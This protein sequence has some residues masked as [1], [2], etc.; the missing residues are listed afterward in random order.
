LLQLHRKVCITRNE[1]SNGVQPGEK[2]PVF[3]T[4]FG[5]VGMM[6]CYDGFFPE[7][8]RE[9]TA[10]GAEVIAWPVWD[11]NPLLARARACENHVYLISSTYT[12]IELNYGFLPGTV[13]IVC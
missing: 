10:N 6:V 7:V 9:L 3:D 5:K 2:Y 11:C 4:R 13:I 1:I 12:G 8:A